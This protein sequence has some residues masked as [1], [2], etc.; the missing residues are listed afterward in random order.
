MILCLAQVLTEDDLARLDELLRGEAYADGRA[1]A[2]WHARLVKRNEQL[3][4]GPATQTAGQI[5]TEALRKNPVFRAGVLPRTIRPPLFSRYTPDM[6]Y[7]SH[8]DNA[9]MGDTAPVRS[10]VSVTVFLSAPETYEGGAL[11]IE[12]TGGEQAFKL[13]AGSA[14]AYP[15]T[16]LHR[17][18]PVAAGERRVAVTW[19]QSLVRAAEK[20]EILF[21]LET[22]RTSL[23]Q[24]SGKTRDFDLLSKTQANLLRLWADT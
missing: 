21:D 19:V 24:T 9:L 2:G 11:V 23:F 15:S 5:V 6:A 16:A 13:D 18:E 12:S 10:D 22:A 8:V 17:V 3:S 7:G 1:T 14:I 4:R 20:R